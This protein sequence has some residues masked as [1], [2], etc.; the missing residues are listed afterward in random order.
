MYTHVHTDTETFC[1]LYFLMKSWMLVIPE[2]GQNYRLHGSH[3]AAS[4]D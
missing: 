1:Y 3:M 2:K 4:A